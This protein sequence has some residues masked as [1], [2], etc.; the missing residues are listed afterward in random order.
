M[1]FKSQSLIL[2]FG[3]FALVSCSKDD[4][5]PNESQETYQTNFEMTDAP[6]DDSNVSA[7]F[8][9]VADVQVDGKSL[10][11]FTKTTIELSSLVNGQTQSLGNLDLRAQN[12]SSLEL[13]LDNET[14]ASGNSPGSYVELANG[15]KDKLE[16][17]FSR[18]PVNSTFEVLARSS[19]RVIID[20]DL[21]KTIVKEE[22]NLAADY[23]FASASRMSTGIRTV[24]QEVTGSLRGTI[25]D[26]QSNS[27]K[28][29]AYA[30]EK[31]TFN[32][33][34]ET[35]GEL[36]FANAITSSAASGLNNEFNLSFLKEGE[37]EIIFAS[38]NEE[39][40]SLRFNSFLEVQSATGIDLGA[41]SISSSLQLSANV[42][43]V[44]TY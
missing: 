2:F 12:Y 7:V 22:S 21:R 31:G 41:I 23:K 44:G 9:T 17:S 10:D 27:D 19:N 5:G 6:V 38:Y 35:S 28:I 40:G 3:I 32:A 20:F 14:D 26:S 43:V 37:Y 24:N 1:N 39:N 29:I 33:E 30:Y 13:V 34:S 16:G 11:G 15:E 18:I 36:S 8:V 42:S 4:A 25:E